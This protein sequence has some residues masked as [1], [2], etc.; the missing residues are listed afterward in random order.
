[1]DNIRNITR[2]SSILINPHIKRGKHQWPE[3]L[4]AAEQINIEGSNR[5]PDRP[6]N[7]R[8]PR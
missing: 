4:Y 7:R 5:A 8:T 3:V 1:M 2:R 6:E